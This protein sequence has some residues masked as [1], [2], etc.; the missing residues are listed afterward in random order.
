MKTMTEWIGRIDDGASLPHLGRAA[1]SWLA[2]SIFRSALAG[3]LACLIAAC[4]GADSGGDLALDGGLDGGAE[5]TPGK[6]DAGE[7]DKE[8]AGDREERPE[9]DPVATPQ[10]VETEE[11][12]PVAITLMGSAS[13]GGDG[14]ELRFEILDLPQHGALSGDAPHLIYTPEA[15]FTGEDAFTFR[16]IEGAAHSEPAAVTITVRPSTSEPGNTPPIAHAQNVLTDEDTP[17][18]ITLTGS[19][20]DDDA[21]SFEIASGPSHGSLSGAPPSVTYTPDAGFSG[22]DSFTF[23]ASD[24]KDSSP[25][26]TVNITVKAA[27]VPPVNTPPVADP[28][29]VNTTSATSIPITLTG[30]DADGDALSFAI[31]AQPSHGSL[32]GTAPEIIYTP[33]VGFSGADS[34][35]F[36]VS[37]GEATSAP[38]LVT[39][40]VTEVRYSVGGTLSGRRWAG[41]ESDLVLLNNGE[42]LLVVESTPFE[43]PTK[44]ANGSPYH[45]T[46]AQQLIGQLCSVVENGTGIVDGADV[47]DIHV[48]CRSW[49]SLLHI[50]P[51][52]LHTSWRETQ[53]RIDVDEDGNAFAVWHQI[54]SRPGGPCPRQP[55][56][57][58]AGRY[59]R[60]THSWSTSTQINHHQS[61]NFTSDAAVA[62][63]GGGDAIAIW[64]QADSICDSPHYRLY[65]SVYSSSDDS[66][67]DPT[68]LSEPDRSSSSGVLAGS[69]SGDAIVLLGTSVDG[70]FVL[71]ARHF[72]KATGVWS[73]A[74]PISDSSITY[75]PN[76]FSVKFTGDGAIAVWRRGAL[77][78]WVNHMAPDGSWGVP[79]QLSEAIPSAVEHVDLAV[80]NHGD[81]AVS[82]LLHRFSP[83][84][85]KLIVSRYYSSETSTWEPQLIMSELGSTPPPSWTRIDINDAGDRVAV[86][87]A[88]A[89]DET[90]R[91][92][93]SHFSAADG[94]WSEPQIIDAGQPQNADDITIRPE[95]G[96]DED[97]NAIAVWIYDNVIWS[98]RYSYGSKTWESTYSIPPIFTPDGTDIYLDSVMYKDRDL[99]L[100]YEVFQWDYNHLSGSQ[101]RAR[102]AVF[103]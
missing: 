67:S 78:L 40:S 56:R 93:G 58:Y 22:A 38:A 6:G 44:L 54:N 76:D 3:A 39:I 50:N 100:A 46:V 5:K 59:T 17:I 34:F 79:Q 31:T 4:G 42:D 49:G 13:D 32:S 37:D 65:A 91:I 70:A 33:E 81:A 15:E 18:A 96:I 64:R 95:L 102:F 24:G 19:D 45:I 88:Q 20:A 103:K 53:P 101:G 69:P 28:Q 61:N 21:L 94:F 8:D 99:Y 52:Y 71:M 74:V 80:N 43:F 84:N 29:T 26:A 14:S 73:A 62:A 12:K 16:V 68:L 83:H 63:I 23:T 55:W 77:S 72:N 51:D 9:G 41:F 7:L 25:A 57:V 30:S 87:S 97:G 35:S 92:W 10:S 82:W 36:T 66:W 86:W 90:V 1:R 27:D 2:A 60:E 11:G 47:D 48:A 85:D 98:N 89:D 75:A